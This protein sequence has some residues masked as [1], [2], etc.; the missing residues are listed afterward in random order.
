[1]VELIAI[2]MIGIILY[3]FFKSN[4]FVGIERQQSLRRAISDSQR[5]V[6]RPF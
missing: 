4:R 5:K 6:R 3:P 1:M 2:A